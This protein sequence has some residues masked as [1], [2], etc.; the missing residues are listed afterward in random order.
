M[1]VA[2]AALALVAT[3]AGTA[4]SVTSAQQQAKSAKDTAK[5]NSDVENNNAIAAQQQAQAE[6]TQIRRTNRLRAGAARAAYGKAGVDISSGNDVLY[7]V[8]TQGELEA[9]SSLYAGS[10]QAGYY[11]SRG[12]GA[13]FEGSNAV[14]A[15][16]SQGTSSIIG[17]VSQAASIGSSYYRNRSGRG[18]LN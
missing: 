4:V 1:P 6:A 3:A 8:G 5:F 12:A 15:A 18:S 11:Q 14:S 16:R 2:L 7:D 9:L 10:T 17:G 13:R